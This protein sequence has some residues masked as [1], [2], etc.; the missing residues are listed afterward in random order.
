MH[1]RGCYKDPS[2][3]KRVFYRDDSAP[4]HGVLTHHFVPTDE[5]RKWIKLRR[6]SSKQSRKDLLRELLALFSKVGS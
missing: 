1:R 4:V 2:S 6:W 3:N 5:L